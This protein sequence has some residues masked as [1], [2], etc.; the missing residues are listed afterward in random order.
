MTSTDD[1][2]IDDIACAK[3]AAAGCE[4][5]KAV[6]RD[7]KLFGPSEKDLSRHLRAKAWELEEAVALGLGRHPRNLS[8]SVIREKCPE[9]INMQGKLSSDEE[10]PSAQLFIDR[11]D[12]LKRA[13]FIGDIRSEERGGTLWFKPVDLAAYAQKEWDYMPVAA[14]AL[15]AATGADEAN[16]EKEKPGAPPPAPSTAPCGPTD[17]GEK[18][19]PAAPV[20]ASAVFD[21]LKDEQGR[22]LKD[23]EGRTL[24]DKK[25]RL[26]KVCMREAWDLVSREMTTPRDERKYKSSTKLREHCEDELGV[27][28]RD[29]LTLVRE[30][31]KLAG[32]IPYR[33]GNPHSSCKSKAA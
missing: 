7:R 25:G 28:F 30:A 29:C 21:T 3:L 9:Q 8:L 2:T 14:R 19:P 1:F 13:A 10:L 6:L 5:P 26:R 32:A 23:K 16:T 15:M 31:K 11:Y 18:K 17:T 12:L 22:L 33:A 24:K 20:S 27:P 4:N